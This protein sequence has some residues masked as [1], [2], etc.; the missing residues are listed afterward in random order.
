MFEGFDSSYTELAK[1]RDLAKIFE[2]DRVHEVAWF[3]R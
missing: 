3:P 1:P 2:D